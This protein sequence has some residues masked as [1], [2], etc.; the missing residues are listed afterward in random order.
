MEDYGG[1]RNLRGQRL[2]QILIMDELKKR[3]ASINNDL[4]P[5]EITRIFVHR[6]DDE[7]FFEVG[8]LALTTKQLKTIEPHIV[9]W[10][11]YEALRGFSGTE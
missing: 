1:L 10:T 9:V 8:R 2:Y 3:T 4:S 6:L 11:G 7:M 5:T